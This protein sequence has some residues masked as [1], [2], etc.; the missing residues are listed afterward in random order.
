MSVAPSTTRA[1]AGHGA[2]APAAPA[3]RKARSVPGK[4]L[5]TID[6]AI[7]AT[8]LR[9]GAT[10]SFHHHLRNGDGVLNAVMARLASAGLRHLHVSASAIFPVHAPLVEHIRNRVVDRI[11]AGYISG[12]VGTAI[13]QGLLSKPAW[14][15]THGGR[16]R[17][18]ALGDQTIDVAFVAASAADEMGNLSGRVGRAPC[19]VLGYPMV[20]VDHAKQVVAVTDTLRPF[21]L[22]P[23]DI[24]QDKVDHVVCIDTIGDP[25]GIASGSTRP[26]TDSQSLAIAAHA[27]G[28]IAASGLLTDEFGFQTGAG[29]ISLAT[30]RA[31]G[32]E[33]RNRGVTGRFACGGIT[34][35]HVDMLEARLF[36][37]LLDVQCFDLRAVASY[38]RNPRHMAMSAATY[39]GPH[40]GGAVVDRLSAVVLG[41][42]E[43]DVNFNV[44]V[45]TRSTGEIIGGSGGHA[46]AAQGAALTV[47]TTRLTAAGWAKIVPRVTTLTTPGDHVDVIVTEAGI[48]VNP[49]RPDLLD[50]FRRASL[51]VVPIADLARQAANLASKVQP[52]ESGGPVVAVSEYRDGTK[53]DDIRAIALSGSAGPAER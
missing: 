40:V 5:A 49:K 39:A 4:A 29:G 12:P 20:D 11:S 22:S 37:S 45:T 42:A 17:S 8:G 25:A 15:T 48:A 32:Q 33:M 16:A 50:R 19:G 27:S 23:I 21:P 44:N 24:A 43:V 2:V 7:A 47:I 26:A 38:S 52:P 10:V 28:A 6:D 18:I 31:V 14:L 36:R 9:D 53:L 1:S 41:A 46:D 35:F 13:S 51:P 34:G 30:A 3:E